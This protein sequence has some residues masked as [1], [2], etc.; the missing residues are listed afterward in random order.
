MC[1]DSRAPSWPVTL[2]ALALVINPRLGLRH[3]LTKATLSLFVHKHQAHYAL[4]GRL[5]FV[6]LRLT[7]REAN[8]RVKKTVVVDVDTFV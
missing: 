8:G 1:C 4:L 2:Q 6:K 3:G 7:Y 5:Q